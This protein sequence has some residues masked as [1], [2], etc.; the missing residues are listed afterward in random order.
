MLHDVVERVFDGS[1]T[2]VMQN[3]IET[4]DLDAAELQRIRQL[5]NRKGRES[6]P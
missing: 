1:V 3:L 6:R 4:S 2:A 5:V